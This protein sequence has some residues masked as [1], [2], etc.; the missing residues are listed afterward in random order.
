MKV[1][2]LCKL[3]LRNQPRII[4]VGEIV[5]I[6]EDMAQRMLS[7]GQALASDAPY[8]DPGEPRP[9]LIERLKAANPA[10]TRGIV[11]NHYWPDK[12]GK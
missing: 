12:G 7:I 1:R 9:K 3:M 5:D 8:I 4:E 10:A 2:T 6:G 11:P